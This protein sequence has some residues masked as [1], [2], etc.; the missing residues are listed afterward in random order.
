LQL[1]IEIPQKCSFGGFISVYIDLDGVFMT[2]LFMELIWSQEIVTEY[3][4]HARHV[5]LRKLDKSNETKESW[6]SNKIIFCRETKHIRSLH[7][8]VNIQMPRNSGYL[9]HIMA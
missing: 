1:F 8:A 6:W 3:K 7:C 4:L 9:L 2:C 5:A